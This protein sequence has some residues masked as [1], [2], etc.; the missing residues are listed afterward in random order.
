MPKT[1]SNCA[2][3]R[4]VKNTS[5]RVPEQMIGECRGG[6]PC[7]DFK[8]PRSKAN[9]F[10]SQHVS[11]AVDQVEAVAFATANRTNAE[12]RTPNAERRSERTAEA[13]ENLFDA[14]RATEPA[15]GSAAAAATSPSTAPEAR[16][17]SES[18]SSRRA[19]R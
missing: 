9:D 4:V 10:C 12:H 15:V 13:R 16:P 14:G 11:H 3:W 2:N 5:L 7:G 8:W 6:T 18:K 17:A 19:R 1:C